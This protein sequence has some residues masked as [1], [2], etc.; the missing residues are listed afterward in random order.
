MQKVSVA[1]YQT[2]NLKEQTDLHVNLEI[3]HQTFMAQYLT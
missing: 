1:F 3:I 2:N